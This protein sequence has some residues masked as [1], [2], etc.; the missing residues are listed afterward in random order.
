[1]LIVR[2]VQKNFIC[3]RAA[4][5]LICAGRYILVTLRETSHLCITATY[6]RTDS[7]KVLCTA[8]QLEVI[9]WIIQPALM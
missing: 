7:E 6:R 1:M 2:N 3:D 4:T 5:L 9:L 8:K